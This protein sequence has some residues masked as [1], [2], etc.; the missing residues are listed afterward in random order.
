VKQH[1]AVIMSLAVVL[2]FAGLLTACSNSS[3]TSSGSSS[4]GVTS[5][6]LWDGWTQYDASSPWGKLLATCEG[7]TGISISRTSDTE[8]STKLLQAASSDS[9]P[10]LAILDNPSVAQFAETGLL[11]DN[12]TSGLDTTQVMANVLAAGQVGGKSYGSSLGANTLALFYNKDLF[13]AAGLTPPTTW[14]ELESDAA[15]LT[16]GDVK[17]IGFSALGTEEGT[18]QFL[19]F[20]WGAGAKLTDISSAD[21]VKALQ[22]WTDLV[23]R[24]YASQ[25]NLNANQQDIRDQFMA[26]KLGMMVNGT[27]QLSTLDKAATPYAVVPIPGVDSG[28]APSPLGGEFIEIVKSD[29]ARQ[30]AASKF[31]QCVIKPDNLKD[32]ASGQSYIMPYTAASAEQ[33]AANPALKPWVAAVSTAQGRTSDLGSKYPATSKALWTAMQEALSGVKTPQVRS[34]IQW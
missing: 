22:F 34:P 14:A 21:S 10:D 9:T 32:W 6:T 31:A 23:N 19:P 8:I 5:L 29:N 17:G 15:A 20:Y 24:G 16:K 7:Q 2:P 30:A 3:G 18:F 4:G 12:G 27:W 11:I 1:R 13:T 26:G 25:S 28:N 33:A